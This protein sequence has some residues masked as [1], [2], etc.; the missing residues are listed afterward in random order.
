MFLV[1]SVDLSFESDRQTNIK[2]FRQTDMN[3]YI[4]TYRETCMDVLCTPQ[5]DNKI[6]FSMHKDTH[7]QTYAAEE[8]KKERKEE[9][10]KIEQKR[11]ERE[12]KRKEIVDLLV[13]EMN[14]SA[15]DMWSS[16][17]SAKK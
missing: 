8:R 4:Q 6:S 17:T 14:T 16:F 10:K 11:K 2:T 13:E 5:G 1:L 12:G 9:R 7:T 3:T 15:A